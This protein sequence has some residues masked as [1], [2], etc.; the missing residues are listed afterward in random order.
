[1]IVENTEMMKQELINATQNASALKEQIDVL[2]AHLNEQDREVSS[3]QRQV[4]QLSRDKQHFESEAMRFQEESRNLGTDLAALTRE[5]QS[6]H[7]S[8]TEVS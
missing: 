3:L 8:L 1:V 7:S 6:L 4:D 5:S 2:G